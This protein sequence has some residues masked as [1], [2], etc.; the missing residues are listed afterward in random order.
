VGVSR[1]LGI[2]TPHDVHLKL[3][4][5]SR[6]G[7]K[8]LRDKGSERRREVVVVSTEMQFDKGNALHT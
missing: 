8:S 5:S 7:A 4:N 1:L 2:R 6:E 3:I